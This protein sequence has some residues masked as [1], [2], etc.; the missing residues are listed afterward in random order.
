MKRVYV[1]IPNNPLAR[2]LCSENP[3][4]DV[5]FA[6]AR[7][8]S[9]NTASDGAA[10]AGRAVRRVFSFAMAY[11]CRVW[12]GGE[13]ESYARAFADVARDGRVRPG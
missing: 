5:I 7:S 13:G 6:G 12:R 1:N 9:G 10:E 11:H 3:V 2:S 4:N 8:A